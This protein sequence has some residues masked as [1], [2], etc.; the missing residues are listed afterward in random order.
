[1]LRFMEFTLQRNLHLKSEDIV[2]VWSGNDCRDPS[3]SETSSILCKD[4]VLIDYI[5]IAAQCVHLY[6]A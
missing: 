1:M 5:I 2:I 6:F 3:C 4:S